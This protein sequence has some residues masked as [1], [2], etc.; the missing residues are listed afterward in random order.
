MILLP[1]INID[2]SMYQKINTYIKLFGI[3]CPVL[4][5]VLLEEYDSITTQKIE[6]I[7]SYLKSAY[8]TL[9]YQYV[10]PSLK[11]IMGGNK[12]RLTIEDISCKIAEDALL[13]LIEPIDRLKNQ[14]GINILFNRNT[15]TLCL[16]CVGK[17][18]DI[19]DL[20][21]GNMNPHQIISFTLP[22]EYGWNNEWWKYAKFEFISKPEFEA[23]KFIRLKK[24]EMLGFDADESIFSDIYYPLSLSQVEIIMEYSQK[25]Y[26]SFTN[27]SEFVVSCSIDENWKYVFWDIQTPKGKREIYAR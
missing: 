25:I 11:P 20:N 1:S 3:G 5:S 24:L 19:S 12:I 15:S 9:R 26:T 18:F 23:S 17:G 7:R 6:E 8:C 10:K 22:I 4:K 21:R 16:E 13:W 27:E 2:L 14:Y